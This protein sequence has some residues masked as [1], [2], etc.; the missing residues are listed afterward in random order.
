LQIR[1]V[2]FRHVVLPAQDPLAWIS[3]PDYV[4]ITIRATHWQ[5]TVFTAADSSDA[6]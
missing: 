2:F 4:L 3:H 6:S 1:A 5:L